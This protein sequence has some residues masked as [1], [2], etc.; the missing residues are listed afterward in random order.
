MRRIYESDAVSRDDDSPFTPRERDDS[1]RPRAM[2][3]VP[4]GALSRLLLPHSLRYRAISVS[5]STPRDTYDVDEP[6]PFA[7]TMRNRLPVA[8]TVPTRSPL[9]WT[10]SVDGLRE[11]SQVPH[12]PPD[13]RA[14]F[15]FD[16]GERKTFR[17]RW[18]QVFRVTDDEWKA[19][20]PGEYTI[21]A[22]IN[23]ADAAAKGVYDETTVRVE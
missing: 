22:G 18:R 20:G 3:S 16:R 5:V 13:E 14:G 4:S 23:V 7:V 10:W 19:A 17:R 15:A 11:A 12:D 1:P 2:R 6:V 21:G 9:L 8:V